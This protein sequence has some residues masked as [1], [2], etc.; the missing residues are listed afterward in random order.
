MTLAARR[1]ARAARVVEAADFVADELTEWSAD[2]K[3]VRS[4]VLTCAVVS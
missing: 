1:A 2:E 4:R 3:K